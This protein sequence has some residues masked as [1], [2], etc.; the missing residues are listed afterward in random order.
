MRILYTQVANDRLSERPFS[1]DLSDSGPCTCRDVI[2][3]GKNAKRFPSLRLGSLGASRESD[4]PHY[5][6][7]KHV[8]QAQEPQNP[9]RPVRTSEETGRGRLQ[10]RKHPGIRRVDVDMVHGTRAAYFR[11]G[12]ETL[13]AVEPEGHSQSC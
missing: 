12:R 3:R 9:H 11:G 13:S 8:C 6:L 10:Q 1:K 4:I 7:V 2:A 5:P